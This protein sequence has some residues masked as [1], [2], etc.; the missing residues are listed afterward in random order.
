MHNM[1]GLPQGHFAVRPGPHDGVGRQRNH[2]PAWLWYYGAMPHRAQDPL[3]AAASLVMA[4][5]TIV[6]RNVDPQQT[7]VVT[8]G[9]LHAGSPTT[10]SPRPRRWS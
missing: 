5:Q 1:P 7:A 9:A 8:V 6:S 2:H 10:S 4:L 3:V